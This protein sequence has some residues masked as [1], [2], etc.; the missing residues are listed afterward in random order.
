MMTPVN[1]MVAI[2][3]IPIPGMKA[4]PHRPY[5]MATS[6]DAPKEGREGLGKEPLHQNSESRTVAGLGMSLPL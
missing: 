3:H 6:G 4:V 1:A 2:L 5:T